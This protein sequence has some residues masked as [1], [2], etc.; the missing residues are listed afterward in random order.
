MRLLSK[1]CTKI[2]NW[3]GTNHLNPLKTLWINL[4]LLPLKQALRFPIYIYGNAS[5]MDL[6]GTMIINGPLKPGIVKLNRISY[7]PAPRFSNAQFAIRGTWVVNGRISLESGTKLY[8]NYGAKLTTGD[9]I[10]AGGALIVVCML[11]VT[12]GDEVRIGHYNQLMDSNLHFTV[13]LDKHTVSSGRKTIDVGHNCWITNHVTIYGGAKIPPF[14]TLAKGSI[15][16]K[17]ITDLGEGN[18]VGGMPLKV[19]GHIKRIVNPDRERE[20]ELYFNENNG[21]PFNMPDDINPDKWFKSL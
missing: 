13:N 21:A 5:C 6:S 10:V 18:M 8:V 7:G 15:A 12:I 9:G 16:N 1:I 20:L 3:M 2:E 11:S 17:D 4:R 19:L 14:T